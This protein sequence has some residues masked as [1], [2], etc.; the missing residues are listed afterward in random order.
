ME[1]QLVYLKNNIVLDD[2]TTLTIGRRLLDATRVGYRYIIVINEKSFESVPLYEFN[3]RKN[4]YKDYLTQE[5]LI[6]YIREKT[7]FYDCD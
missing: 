5:Q 6:H 2:R 3:D 4:N 1:K 7:V